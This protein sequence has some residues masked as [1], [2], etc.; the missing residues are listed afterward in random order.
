MVMVISLAVANAGWT[1]GLH[2]VPLASLGAF[3]IG[4]MIAKSLLPGWL[5]HLFSLIIGFAWSFRL[6]TTLFPVYYSWALR[7]GWLWWYLYEWGYKLIA[8]GISYNNLVF[9]LHM[10]FVGW[11]IT[12]MTV[13]FIFRQRRI[14]HAV[15]S[16]GVL[17]L[18]NVYYAPRDLT[19]YFVV[20]LILTLLLVIRF[21]LFVQTQTWRR[22]QVHFNAGEISFDFLR[23][24]TLFTGLIIVLALVT[25]GAA[26]AE[27]ADVF[28]VLRGP[29]HDLQAEWSRLFASLNY[30]PSGS[31]DFYGRSLHL[32]GPRNLAEIPILEVKAP[33]TARYWRAAVF[34][35]FTGRSWENTDEE[36]VPFGADNETLPLIT[37]QA[38]QPVT[39]TVTV[40]GPG[41]SSLVMA[42][43]PIWVSRSARVNVSYVSAAGG[44]AFG[45]LDEIAGNAQID[46]ISFA[47]SRIPLK[48]GEGYTVASLITRASVR[49][50]QAAGVN[51]PAWV[52]ERYLQLPPSVPDRVKRLAQD[53]TVAY[54]NPYDKAAAI[55]RF[56]RQEI[57]YNEKINA[58]P[59]DRDPVDY[60]LF[61]LRQ[62]YCDYYATSMVV[63]L[64]S[65]GIPSRIASGFAQGHYDDEREAYVVLQQDAHTWVE[66]FFPNYGWVEFEPTAAQ[67]AIVRPVEPLD[68]ELGADTT[69]SP[70]RESQPE[71]PPETPEEESAPEQGTASFS[72]WARL[73]LDKP[74]VWVGGG[75]MLAL[76]G[77]A[78][79]WRRRMRKLDRVEAI[80]TSML[81]WAGWVGASTR[82]SQTPYEHA[83]ALG[84]VV[85]EGEAPARAIAE[86]YT[87]GRYSHH[88]PDEGEQEAADRAWQR[89]RPLLMRALLRRRHR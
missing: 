8:G 80:Y 23:A 83:T 21:N 63:M 78:V 16:G 29:W 22:E 5:G 81:R 14:W 68:Q 86:V 71:L 33:P 11:G 52:T 79:W 26:V 70:D 72:F 17:L 46:T 66:V 64:R 84:Q 18:V 9:V 3:I 37:Y 73:A 1:T 61:D 40:L 67:P 89:L 38:R 42:A 88:R 45:P 4:L 82:L 55:E 50:L 57:A 41:M 59:A 69:Q 25:P 6:V 32:G 7:W 39:Q 19:A 51:Y 28:D 27:E 58:P 20:Y 74:E 31:V 35:T 12:Y 60:I 10:A 77:G 30:R 24:G 54:D 87:R 48:A 53:L 75:L 49:Q 76:V 13:W 36:L 15:V 34:D 43:Q 65:L 2:L 44:G 56:L 47:R 85:P 62:A